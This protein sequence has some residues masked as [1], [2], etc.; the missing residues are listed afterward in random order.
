[1]FEPYR[2]R[3]RRGLTVLWS[4]A[5]GET[6]GAEQVTRERADRGS[7][8]FIGPVACDDDGPIPV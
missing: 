7:A 8:A 1:M 2:S 6:R 3:C 4:G 5:G